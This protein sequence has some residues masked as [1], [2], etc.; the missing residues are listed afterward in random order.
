MPIDFTLTAEQRHLQKSARAFAHDVLTRVGATTHHLPTPQARFA[1][2]RP[3]YEEM[4]AAGFLRRIIPAQLGGDGTGVLD[5]AIMA[6]EFYAV[7]ANVS[8]TL[9]GTLLSLSPVLLADSP[10]QQTRFLKPFTVAQGAPLA[11]FAF[12][13]PGGSANF[14]APAPAEG[15]RT[16]RVVTATT[17]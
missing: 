17:G 15:V 12:S 7:D 9:F 4:I 13:E 6:E 11:A 8:L 14:A 5:M 1:A 16:I 2:T 10:A 3:F